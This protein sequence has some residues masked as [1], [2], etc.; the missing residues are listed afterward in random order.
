MI[1]GDGDGGAG[2]DGGVVGDAVG[3]VVG[4]VVGDGD[5]DG[6]GPAEHAVA[7]SAA[8]AMTGR[9]RRRSGIWSYYGSGVRSSRPKNGWSATG[10]RTDPSACW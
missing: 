9:V 7:I 8:A 4:D 5:G 10:I 3:D 2:G 1:V 6:S